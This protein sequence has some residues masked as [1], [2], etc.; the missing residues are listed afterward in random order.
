MPAMPNTSSLCSILDHQITLDVS[1]NQIT[2]ALPRFG[3]RIAYQQ[4]GGGPL[5][6]HSEW[7]PPGKVPGIVHYRAQAWRLA[8]DAALRLGWFRKHQGGLE[9]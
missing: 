1:G 8:N 6:L 4:V 3:A 2:V 7:V 9:R 5:I